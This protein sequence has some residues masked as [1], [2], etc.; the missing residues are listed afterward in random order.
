MSCRLFDA[1]NDTI[2]KIRKTLEKADILQI[3]SYSQEN[4]KW[5]H[6]QKLN[7]PSHLLTKN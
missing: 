4:F 5:K 7:L 6:D 3:I 2:I 1:I